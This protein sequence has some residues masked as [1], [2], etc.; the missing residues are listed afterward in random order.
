[1]RKVICRLGTA[2]AIALI[3]VMGVAPLPG[4]EYRT[5]RQA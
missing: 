1:M 3:M 5:R 2:S 4:Q